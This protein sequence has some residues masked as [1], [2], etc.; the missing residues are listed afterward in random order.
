MIGPQDGF[1][2]YV[3]GRANELETEDQLLELLS[4]IEVEARTD[5]DEVI[6]LPD[7]AIEA[8]ALAEDL[9]ASVEAWTSLVSY[10]LGV[11]YAPASPWR[12]DKAGWSKDAVEKSRA[13]GEW[14]LQHCRGALQKVGVSSLA[15]GA[16]FP[17]GIT[18]SVS[19]NI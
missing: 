15:V 9:L 8:A 5:A 7:D 3:A 16:A 14:L 10:A 11:F 12:H 6:H 18:V 17:F 2:E 19:W 13:L 1:R 4:Q